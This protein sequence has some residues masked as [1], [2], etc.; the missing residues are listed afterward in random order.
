MMNRSTGRAIGVLEHITQSLADII[1]TPLGSRVMRRDYGS[2]V[3]YLIDQ[4][5]NAATQ[6][7]LVAAVTSAVM[8]WEPR[9][10]LT[11]VSI[12]H[13]VQQP[14]RAEIQLRGRYN[15]PALPA[16]QAL[17]VGITISGA[18]RA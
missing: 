2:L 5:D 1:T 15:I 11:R 14:G 13:D 8:K 16:P 3:P 12:G 6:L 18:A 10:H 4:P 9:V 17:K 7:R